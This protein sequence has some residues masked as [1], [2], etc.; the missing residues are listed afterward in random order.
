MGWRRQG[1]WWSRRILSLPHLIQLDNIHIGI[2]SPEYDPETG[3]TN[4]TTKDTEKATSKK[5]RKVKMR[6]G[7]ETDH[8]HP[9]WGGS[10]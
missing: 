4:S 6:F 8:I 7:S 3:R 5:V 2:N 9:Q 10:Q 1:R